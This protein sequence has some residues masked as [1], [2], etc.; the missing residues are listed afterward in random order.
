MVIEE[1]ND[2]LLPQRFVVYQA[3]ISPDEWP[4]VEEVG[5][6]A[7]NVYTS[8]EEWDVILCRSLQDRN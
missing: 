7:G 3:F 1:E 6:G 2:G 5:P 4:M 8:T